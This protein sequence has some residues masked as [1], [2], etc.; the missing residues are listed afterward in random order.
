[1][2][3]SFQFDKV[4]NYLFANGE[5]YTLR[6]ERKS[7]GKTWINLKRGSKKIADCNV[8]FVKIITCKEDLLPYV[9]K[10]GL[11]SIDEWYNLASK[12]ANHLYYVTL[13]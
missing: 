8:E 2:P 12:D 5:V 1:M 3:I 11:S 13:I 6:L 10:S 7:I 9:S 4:R